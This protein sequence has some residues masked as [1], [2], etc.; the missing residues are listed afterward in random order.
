MDEHSPDDRWQEIQAIHKRHKFFYQFSGGILLVVFG[1]WIGS[2]LFAEDS[3]YTTN[4]YTEL[5]GIAVTVLV[6]NL[7]AQRRESARLKAQLVRELGSSDNAIALRALA[8]LKAGGQ[9]GDGSLT[10]AILPRAN[11]KNADFP[12]QS[13]STATTGLEL[14]EIGPLSG[15]GKVV[16]HDAFLY[17][18]NLENTNLISA[19]LRGAYLHEANLKGANLIWADLREADLRSAD[20]ERAFLSGA[21]LERANLW[22]ANLNEAFLDKANLQGAHHVTEEQLAKA[23]RLRRAM[24]CGRKS[25]QN[26]VFNKGDS[27]LAS[28][29]VSNSTGVR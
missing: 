13:I 17:G 26:Y 25:G 21:N 9:V 27:G 16:L 3:G 7:L 29:A 28:S 19:E 1:V 18:A 11:L 22:H 20:L 14:P 15:L 24:Y 4:L 8:E 2:L 23:H 10:G 12:T 6:L 5:L